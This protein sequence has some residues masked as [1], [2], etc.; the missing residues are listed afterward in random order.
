MAAPTREE[1]IEFNKSKLGTKEYWEE[2]YAR[3]KQAFDETK[4]PGDVWFGQQYVDKMLRIV[5][6]LPGVTKHSRIV[7]LGTGNGHTLVEFAKEGG[8]TALVGTD[9]SAEAVALA[10]AYVQEEQLAEQIHLV[11]DDVLDSRLERHSFHVVLDKGTFDAIMLSADREQ[12]QSKYIETVYALL[13][14]DG[15]PSFLVISSCN[16]TQA[17]LQAIFDS[18]FTFRL[19][20]KYSGFTFGGVEGFKASTV[21][22]EKRPTPLVS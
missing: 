19:A 12:A 21:C 11:Q 8:F 18:H 5:D 7:D 10:S 4:D 13:L 15:S 17:E 16:F 9:Y 22:F 20:A 2:I 6:A 3:D 14:D 1:I